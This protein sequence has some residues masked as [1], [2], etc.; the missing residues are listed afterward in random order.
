MTEL[1]EAEMA[2]WLAQ[3]RIYPGSDPNATVKS[4]YDEVMRSIQKILDGE[5]TPVEL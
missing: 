5:F 1:T 4:V 3:Y 2:Q